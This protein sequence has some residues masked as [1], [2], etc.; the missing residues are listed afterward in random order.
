MEFKLTYEGGLLGS[1]RTNTRATH[2]HEIRRK[3]HPQLKRLW[4]LTDF[5]GSRTVGRPDT[6][7]GKRNLGDK[8]YQMPMSEWLGD[9]FARCGYRFCPL[10]T[11]MFS[12]SCQLHILFLR[13]EAPGQIVNSGD[14]D[15]RIKTIFDALK[16]PKTL[17]E[18][19]DS[20]DPLEG[21]NPFY[22]L[23]EDD[24]L[25]A[26]LA[27]ETATLLQPIGDTFEVNDCRLVI[28]VKLWPTR[29]TFANLD[30]I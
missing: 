12:L 2:K 21:E 18:L 30:F 3:L 5:L 29:V 24:K 11:E 10:V 15:G 28:S 7:E 14:I 6:P 13:P 19:G 9:Q 20:P 4:K 8:E 17:D 16:T 1:S 27:L 25:I 26:N 23:L 22:T